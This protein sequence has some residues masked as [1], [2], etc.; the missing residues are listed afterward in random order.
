[1]SPDEAKALHARARS[2]CLAL[3]TQRETAEEIAQDV[4]VSYLSRGHTGQKVDFAVVDAI[5]VRLGRTEYKKPREAT[6]KHV[7][8]KA[9][10]R[11]PSE[12]VAATISALLPKKFPPEERAI[13]VLYYAW[14]FTLGEIGDVYGI[15][16]SAGSL[17][18]TAALK[19]LRKHMRGMR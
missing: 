9:L 19:R 17:R 10:R 11:V 14:G 1:M 5:R 8:T 6:F 7:S 13:L 15:T 18:L 12:E 2:R 16:A 3:G 4:M